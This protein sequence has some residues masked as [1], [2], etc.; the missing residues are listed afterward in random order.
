MGLVNSQKF[1]K[2][3]LKDLSIVGKDFSEHFEAKGYLTQVSS[4]PFGA[5]F[6]ITKG[7]MFKSVVG[8]KTALNIDLELAEGGINVKMEVGA[9]GKQVLPTALTMFVAWPVII[10]QLVGLISQSKLDVEAY[11]VI[12]N[13]IRKYDNEI[14][15]KIIFCTNCGAQNMSTAM[16]CYKCGTKLVE[17]ENKCIACKKV[18]PPRTAFCIYC[19]AK[20]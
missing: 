15:E 11:T 5:F 16:F 18:I 8:M 20:Q 17:D 9:F 3:Q 4:S 12:G 14:R 19:G 13:S 1:F 10:P 6:S 2:T 7:G